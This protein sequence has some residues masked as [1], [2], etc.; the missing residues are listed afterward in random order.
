MVHVSVTGLRLRS[1]WQAP[2]FWWH[3]LRSL[4]QARRAPGNLRVE[5]HQVDGVA[6]TLTVWT[7]V[8]AMRAFLTAGAHLAAMWA[9]RSLGTGRTLGYAAPE[10]PPWEE[11]L[12]RWRREAR[13]A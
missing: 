5:A 11:A 10:V 1:A 7:D 2:R 13:E 6:H 4:R 12:D 8:A 9:F 3:T